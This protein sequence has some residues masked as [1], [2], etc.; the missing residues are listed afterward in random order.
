MILADVLTEARGLLQ[1]TNAAASLRRYSDA[2]LLGTANQ[3]LQRM[4]LL[5]PDLFSYIGDITCATGEVLQ[6]A[7]TNSLRL[8]DIF[9]VRGGSGVRETNRAT[10]DQTYPTWAD[11]P[12]GGCLNWMRHVKNANRFF[13]YP[14]APAGQVLVGEYAKMPA[15]YDANT[16]VTELPDAYFPVVVDGVVWLIESADNESVTSGRAAMFMQS[17][18]QTMSATLANQSITDESSSTPGKKNGP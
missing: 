4:A 11:D 13:I 14:K 3:V 8:I 12:D 6:T 15:T 10:I 9:R 1:D 7:P 5:R 2:H 17:F 16:T 18:M